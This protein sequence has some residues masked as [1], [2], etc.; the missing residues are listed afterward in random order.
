MLTKDS[1]GPELHDMDEGRT[2]QE[3]GGREGAEGAGGGVGRRE[4]RDGRGEKNWGK[5]EGG[6]E[7]GKICLRETRATLRREEGDKGV[8]GGEAYHLSNPSWIHRRRSADISLSIQ[9]GQGI[10]GYS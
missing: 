9:R 7:K 1:Q 6:R 4:K 2:G 5:R 10:I 3:G 8:G